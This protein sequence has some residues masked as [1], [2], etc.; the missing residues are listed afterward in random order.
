MADVKTIIAKNVATLF[1]DGDV[2]NL[3]VGIPTMAIS[4][5]PDDVKVTVH[6][7]CGVIGCGDV[8]P[9][10]IATTDIVDA[11][12]IPITL[13]E[14]ASIV[15]SAWSFGIARGGHLSMTVLGGLQV[16][17]EGN[18]ANWMRPGKAVTGMGG[19]MD[20]VVGA[21]K[22]VIAMTHNSKKGDLKIVDKCTM[23]L[24]SLI[25]I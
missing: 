13:A 12:S 20:I 11:S 6:A 10:E 22:V 24:L 15:D 3:G 7:E 23:P 16:D 21:K 25:H 19:A 4:Y 1:S 5:L 17:S 14:G 8:A 2:V 9:P 18:L